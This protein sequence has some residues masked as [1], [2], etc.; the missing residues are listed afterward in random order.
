MAFI[1]TAR[2]HSRSLPQL[3]GLVAF[4][5]ASS[6]AAIAQTP[7][8]HLVERTVTLPKLSVME[9]AGDDQFDATGMGAVQEELRSAPFSNELTEVDFTGEEGLGVEISAELAAISTASPAAAEAG[10]LG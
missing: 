7:A 5:G 10:K 9:H 2:H 4:W 8:V 6:L 3:C 1:Y